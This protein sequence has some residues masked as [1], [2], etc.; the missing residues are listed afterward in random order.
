MEVSLEN[1]RQADF[2]RFERAVM[3]GMNARQADWQIGANVI[4]QRDDTYMKF[5]GSKLGFR[6][7]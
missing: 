6:Y 5:P 7:I 3:I 1:H 4:C 2:D